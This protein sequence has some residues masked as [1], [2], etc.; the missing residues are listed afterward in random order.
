[1]NIFNVLAIVIARLIKCTLETLYLVLHEK[2]RQIR[3]KDAS[4]KDLFDLSLFFGRETF[5]LKNVSR[6][7][8]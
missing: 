5:F 3:T 4:S 6:G 8:S 7:T 1:M 2:R